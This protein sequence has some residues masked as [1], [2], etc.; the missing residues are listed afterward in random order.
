MTN[1][2]DLSEKPSRFLSFTG[3]TVEEFLALLPFFAL[4][5]KEYMV[6]FTFEGKKRKNRKYVEYKNACLGT[7]ENKLL[8][9]LTYIKGNELQEKIAEMWLQV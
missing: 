6:N 8:L 4:K 2:N 1:F 9:I 5:F 7:M 3:Y